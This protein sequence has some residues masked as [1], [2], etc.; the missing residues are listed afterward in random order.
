MLKT[1]NLQKTFKNG[2]TA[3][4]DVNICLEK[5]KFYGI[6]G[7]S[8]SGKT[9]L[10]Q[11][12]SVLDSP[13]EGSVEID[14]TDTAKLKSSE[15]CSL[16]IHKIG[17]IFQSFHLHPS[18]TAIQNVMLPMF[19]NKKLDKSELEVRALKLLELVDLTERKDHL[20]KQL[21]GGEQ[22]RVAIARALANEPDYIFAD[23]PTGNLDSQNEK[24]IFDYLKILSKDRCLVVV[25][26]NDIIK[27]YTDK[28]FEMKDGILTQSI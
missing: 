25:S 6:S 8:G 15:L 12:L 5:G 2:V 9:T 13:S 24:I 26:H 3:V 14:G 4:K 16:R 7:N 18:L 17:F 27:E 23:E 21:S 10:L 1:F 28:L 11:L 22:Q 20:P 19:V